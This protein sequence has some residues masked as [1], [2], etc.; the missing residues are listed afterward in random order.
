M[1]SLRTAL[2]TVA[3]FDVDSNEAMIRRLRAEAKQHLE[4]PST[5]KDDLVAVC[6]LVFDILALQDNLNQDRHR[7]S[8]LH[9]R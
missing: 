2:T 6:R 9:G 7:I 5:S 4:A 3:K 1:P 8:S